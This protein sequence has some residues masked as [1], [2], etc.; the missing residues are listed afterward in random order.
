[1]ILAAFEMDEILS[2]L[3]DHSA[4][5]NSGR[6]GYIC[7]FNLLRPELRNARTQVMRTTH[8]LRSYRRFRAKPC[9]KIVDG[10]AASPS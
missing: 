7:S 5:L 9:K 4:G 3:R 6:S 8:F 1:M 10:Q 2:E